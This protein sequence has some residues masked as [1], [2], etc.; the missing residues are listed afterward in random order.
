[1]TVCEAFAKVEGYGASPLNRPT[2]NNN[3]GDIE[4]G[5]F[6]QSHGATHIEAARPGGT[7]RFAYFPTPDAGFAAMRALFLEHYKGLTVEQAITKYAP[8]IENPTAMYIS[9]VCKL[10]ECSPS[11]LIDDLL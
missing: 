10:A 3:P 4:F 7:A 6:A 8:P 2:R 11:D 9:E 5:P 1:M